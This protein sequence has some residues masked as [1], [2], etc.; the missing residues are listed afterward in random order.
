MLD[1]HEKQQGRHLTKE[2]LENLEDYPMKPLVRIK[3]EYSGGYQALHMKNF[4]AHFKDA[5]ANSTE[6]LKFYKL[7]TRT[8]TLNR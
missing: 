8:E 6:F 4:G 5:I 3:I 1:S 7:K 2:M